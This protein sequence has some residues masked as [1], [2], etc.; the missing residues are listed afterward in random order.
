MEALPF[1][2][3]ND[4]SFNLEIFELN[5][6]QINFNTDRLMDL[7]CN[8]LLANANQHLTLSNDADPDFHFY[9][10]LNFSCDYLNEEQFN[11]I[12][13]KEVNYF[14][15]FSLFHLNIRSL[16]RNLDKLTNL[17]SNLSMRFSVIGI[18]ET[19]LQ[20]TSHLV[21]I[22]GYSFF[23]RFRPNR[24]GG[25]VGLYLTENCDSKIRD[26]LCFVNQ[27]I[28]ESLFI[29]IN[30][31]HGKN[32]IVGVIYRPPNQDLNSFLS[33]Y[34]EL[35]NKVSKENK[36]CYI[37]RDFNLN[38]LNYQQHSL[39]GK[40]LD[41]MY[42]NMFFPVITHPTRITSHSATLI[43]NLFTNQLHDNMKCGLLFSDI[44]DHLP[45]FCICLETRQ[46]V[47]RK[48]K[49]DKIIVREKNEHNYN[50]FREKLTEVNWSE[51]EGFNDPNQSY[52]TFHSRFSLI[53]KF[54]N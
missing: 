43:D 20:H 3:L 12:A 26:D 41:E 6:G 18:T 8:P 50:K 1:H 23:H 25:G 14:D 10:D 13:S 37:M 21:D 40:F 27:E 42:S 32:I 46:T 28:A 38:I 39:T 44:S 24:V 36:I 9:C 11:T 34:N 51:L 7:N 48:N 52:Q 31:A 4:D 47:N 35:I 29:E 30:R 22:H 17:L 49:N 33:G 19:W 45:I 54:P 15:Q 5:N 53:Y 16:E 2:S